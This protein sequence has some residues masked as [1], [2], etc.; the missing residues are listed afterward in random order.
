MPSLIKKIWWNS[1]L[2]VTTAVGSQSSFTARFDSRVG[3][4]LNKVTTHRNRFYLEQ[5]Y[6]DS[7]FQFMGSF[8]AQTEGIGGVDRS[9]IWL[10]DFY[11]GW[12]NQ[13]LNLKL[14]WQQVVWGES[15]GFYF[16]DIVN[17][18]DL[19]ELGLSDLEGNRIT[20]PMFN[21]KYVG[22]GFSAQLILVPVPAIS[23]VA[24][25]GSAFSFPFESVFGSVPYSVS[26]ERQPSYSIE[27]R[28]FGI[29]LSQ[30]WGPTSAS[31]FYFSGLDREPPFISEPVLPLSVNRL[32]YRLQTAGLTT[33][34]DLGS[35]VLRSEIVYQMGKQH[36]ISGPLALSADKSDQWIGVIGGDRVWDNW[37]LGLQLSQ[38]KRTNEL[39]NTSMPSSR[40]QISLLCAGTVPFDWEVILSYIPSDGSQLL[41]P[42]IVIPLSKELE[43]ALSSDLF[44]GGRNSELGHYRDA[45]RILA[46]IRA[47]LQETPH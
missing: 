7:P 18:K 4:D 26:S 14:G 6:S 29:R 39:S 46:Q 15:F 12:K 31:L 38:I 30:Q 19:Y 1:F 40:N 10:R 25:A 28:E 8:R 21:G 44:L 43:L 37:H 5:K 9:E 34:S 16:A 23:R 17:P 27:N 24:R 22:D 35:F 13:N 33:T 11:A 47:H 3:W 2:L 42:K 41:Q 45:S 36:Q 20:I 32:F